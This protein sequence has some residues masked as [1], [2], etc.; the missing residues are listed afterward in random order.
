MVARVAPE[1]PV[2]VARQ[3]GASSL[4]SN[5][6]ASLRQAQSRISIT[7]AGSEPSSPNKRQLVLQRASLG[8]IALAWALLAPLA[9]TL[10]WLVVDLP[11]PL[12]ALAASLWDQSSAT[13]GLQLAAAV[14]ATAA[15]CL[16]ARCGL[17]PAKQKPALRTLLTHAVRAAAV[18]AALGAAAA[19]GCDLP[20]GARAGAG[21][22]CAATGAAVMACATLAAAMY[23]KEVGH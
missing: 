20:S 19:A 17:L 3:P 23:S 12:P 21:L 13:A 16:L 8:S 1:E 5:V 10:P 15:A 7:G 22:L 18:A 9:C 11:A 2:A 14:L 4:R 6:P